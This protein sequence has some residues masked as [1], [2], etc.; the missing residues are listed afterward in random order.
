MQVLELNML[1]ESCVAEILSLTSPSY[2]C[3]SSLVSTTFRSAADSD[4]VWGKFLPSE[5]HESVWEACDASFQFCSKKELYFLLCNPLLVGDGKMSFRLERSSGRMSY[6]ISARELSITWSNDPMLWVWKSIPESRFSEVAELVTT[7]WLEINGKITTK[8]LSP[9]TNYGAFLILKTTERS[10][11]LDLIPCETSIEIGSRT[12]KNT[13]YMRCQDAKKQQIETL[14]YSN[15]KE[16]MKSRVVKGD[17]GVMSKREDGWME[18]ELGEFFN[19]GFGDEQ[20]KMG[21]MEIKGHQLKG[22]VIIEGI[23]IRPKT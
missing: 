3:R 7:S 19:G 16:M 23:E 12:L 20:V 4:Y 1:P 11:G 6:I 5:Y 17:D 22:G 2:A 14:F 21:L 10:F 13:A 15:R 18:M 9:N 8:M